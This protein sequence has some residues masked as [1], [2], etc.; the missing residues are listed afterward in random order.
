VITDLV[1]IHRLGAARESENLEFRRYLASHHHP[2]EPFQA[3]AADIQNHIDCTACANCCRCSVVS[4]EHSEIEAIA[5]HLNLSAN[6]VVERYTVPE[7]GAPALRDLKSNSDGCIFLEGNRCKVYAA[8]PKACREF[9]HLSFGDHSLGARIASLCR[10]A[11]LCPIVYNA[12]EAYKHH[13]GFHA[14][15][16]PNSSRCASRSAGS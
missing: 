5:R 9:P 16:T 13:V 15:R 10:W 8:R 4:V 6:D 14:R 12:L 11:S 7:P 3:L 2:I 1:E